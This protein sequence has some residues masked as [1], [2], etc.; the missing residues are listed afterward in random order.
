MGQPIE[1]FRKKND[2]QQKDQE[3][4][5]GG[6]RKQ[7]T[8]TQRRIGTVVQHQPIDQDEV[9]REDE[10]L[11]NHSQLQCRISRVGTPEQRKESKKKV[12]AVKHR[13]DEVSEFPY[14]ERTPAAQIPVYQDNSHGHAGS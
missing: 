1:F 6:P 5:P 8:H 9:I 10:T 13:N 4:H 7:M 11:Y 12:S 2:A 3:Y 14:R